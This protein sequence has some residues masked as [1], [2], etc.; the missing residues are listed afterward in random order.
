MLQR[1]LLDFLVLYLKM[2]NMINESQ[3]KTVRRFMINCIET[4]KQKKKYIF[5]AILVIAVVIF[6]LGPTRTFYAWDKA[7]SVVRIPLQ[8]VIK[9]NVHPWGH[10]A[11]TSPIVAH[12]VINGIEVPPLPT[13]A[14]AIATFSGVDLNV[15]GVRDD[16]ERYI[17]G[18]YGNEQNRYL[19]IREYVRTAQIAMEHTDSRE[20]FNMNSE[21]QDCFPRKYDDTYA[22]RTF[23]TL[24]FQYFMNT[25]TR[26]KAF[27]DAFASRVT[28]A[29]HCEKFPWHN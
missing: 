17:A 12:E 4:I 18:Q 13:L 25:D 10:F 21:V 29:P 5:A 3:Q 14:D 24:Q 15:D 6:F 27:L 28:P 23:E 1:R 8:K 9:P 7:T 20:A 16:I 11:S 26:A 2:N 19:A 22:H